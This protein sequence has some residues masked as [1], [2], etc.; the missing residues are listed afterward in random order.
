MYNRQNIPTEFMLDNDVLSE[1]ND[2]ILK[3]EQNQNEQA[4]V[5]N[6]YYSFTD[7]LQGEMD[8]HLRWNHTFTRLRY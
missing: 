5:D 3:L 7:I 4:H 6:V 1:I 2:I 8:K